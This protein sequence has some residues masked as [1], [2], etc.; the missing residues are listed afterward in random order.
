MSGGGLVKSVHAQE[1]PPAGSAAPP[2]TPAPEPSSTAAL[3]ERIRILEQRLQELDQRQRS[4]QRPAPSD[5]KAAQKTEQKA[6]QKPDQKPGAEQGPRQGA[7]PDKTAAKPKLLPVFTLAPGKGIGLALPDGRFSFNLRF[8]TQLRDTIL[9]QNDKTTNEIGFKTIRLWLT[10]N[11]LN[12]DIKYGIQLAFGFGDFE[13]GSSTPLFDAFI[14]YTRLRD[15]QIKAGQFFVPFDRLRTIREFALQLVDRPAVIRELSLDRDVGIAFSSQDLFGSHGVL[16]YHLGVFGGE[17]RNRF[18]GAVPGGLYVGRIA[19]RPFGA[20]DDDIEGDLERL[21]RPRLAIG[22][23]GAYNQ[24]TNRQRGTTGNTYTLGT[25]DYAHA[26][27]DLIFKC[28]G[29]YLA[30]EV[31]YRQAW[32]PFREATKDGKTVREWSRSAWGYVI[33]ASAMVHRQVE[34]VG[35]WEHLI[36]IGNTDPTLIQ[37]GKDQNR[38]AGGGLNLYLNGHLFKLQAD[39]FYLFGT[40]TTARGHQLRF[41]LDVS[42]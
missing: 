36:P 38:Q 32:Q 33:Q 22:L 28:A 19:I 24:A 35:R 15:L 6:E 2:A 1:P 3:E 5:P 11:L 39:Y 23:A 4:E 40:T 18:G 41:Q 10:G 9:R 17:G 7:A 27:A 14:E 8:R 21:R 13:T 42:I 26:A 16:S 34:V 30:G 31:L 25:F 20:F 37:T 29:V 12:P